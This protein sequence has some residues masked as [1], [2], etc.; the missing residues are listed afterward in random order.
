MSRSR[1]D[2]D[3]PA[4]PWRRVDH[5][6]RYAEVTQVRRGHRS[7]TALAPIAFP[8]VSALAHPST[9]RPEGDEAN[10]FGPESPPDV[11]F[12]WSVRDGTGRVN[13][14]RRGTTVTTEVRAGRAERPRPWSSDLVAQEVI[15][16]L[17]W[18][19]H[20]TAPALAN[21]ASSRLQPEQ[22][23]A[24]NRHDAEVNLVRGPARVKAGER[25]TSHVAR[26]RS[27]ASSEKP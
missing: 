19:A 22:R 26:R 23:E 10:G 12:L 14:S 17:P 21:A 20:D 7:P 16:V 5:F 8:P 6:P 13:S 4:R 3:A 2:R 24:D 9:V 11:V 27:H 18:P 1:C 15:E 25:A